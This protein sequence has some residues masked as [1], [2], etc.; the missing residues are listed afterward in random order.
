[1]QYGKDFL[2]L[3]ILVDRQKGFLNTFEGEAVAVRQG[4]GNRGN[5]IFSD[6]RLALVFATSSGSIS[7]MTSHT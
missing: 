3:L 7:A 1:M 2:P 4:A 5:P 6:F